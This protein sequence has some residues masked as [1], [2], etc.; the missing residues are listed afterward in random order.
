M[1]EK[2]KKEKAKVQK[3]FGEH[4]RALRKRKGLTVAK[5]AREAFLETSN[6]AKIEGGSANLTLW[7]MIKISKALGISLSELIE[8]FEF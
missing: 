8:D 1:T 4:I 7:S 6:V 5:F 3:R 2:E